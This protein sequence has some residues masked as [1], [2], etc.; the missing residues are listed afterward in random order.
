MLSRAG[1][2]LGVK[3]R[4]T[5]PRGK[6]ASPSKQ[7]Q[8]YI[9]RPKPLVQVETRQSLSKFYISGVESVTYRLN[10]LIVGFTAG[11]HNGAIT[12]IASG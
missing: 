3:V 4:F 8:A 6:A 2:H 1:F 10:V 12:W 7:G 9:R 5:G 11:I